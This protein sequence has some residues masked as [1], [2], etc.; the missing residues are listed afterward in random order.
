MQ[1]LEDKKKKPCMTAKDLQEDLADKGLTK[2]HYT[3]KQHLGKPET[4]WK[5]E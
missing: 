2:H 1:D 4:F 5:Q 3:V